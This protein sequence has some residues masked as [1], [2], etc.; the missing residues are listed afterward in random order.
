MDLHKLAG[1]GDSTSVGI[2]DIYRTVAEKST[3]RDGSA[4]ERRK[5][6]HPTIRRRGLPWADIRRQYIRRHDN[7]RWRRWLWR[8]WWR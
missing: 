5:R 4:A 7:R 2:S 3:N 8:R 6:R 1:N